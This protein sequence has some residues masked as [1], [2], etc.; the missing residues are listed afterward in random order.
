[1]VSA[2]HFGDQ[3]WCDFRAKLYCLRLCEFAYVTVQHADGHYG[4]LVIA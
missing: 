4:V 2:S 1:M 3:G